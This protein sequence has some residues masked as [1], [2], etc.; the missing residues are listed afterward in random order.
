VF[1]PSSTGAP[2]I[3]VVPEEIEEDPGAQFAPIEGVDTS[4]VIGD[5]VPRTVEDQGLKTHQ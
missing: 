1:F 4:G 3:T 2:C 5:I